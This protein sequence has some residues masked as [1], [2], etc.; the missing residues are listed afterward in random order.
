MREV[1]I[2]SIRRRQ[3]ASPDQRRR[4]IDRKEQGSS[5]E[6]IGREESACLFLAHVCEGNARKDRLVDKS[7]PKRCDALV[8]GWASEEERP[9][10]CVAQRHKPLDEHGCKLIQHIWW[11][12][13]QPTGAQGKL[14]E[15][16]QRSDHS[17]R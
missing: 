13:T 6:G 3:C 17:L 12:E 5:D 9:L 15:V 4:K 11:S 2:L 16:C 8:S 10:L 14:S 1:S 7:T